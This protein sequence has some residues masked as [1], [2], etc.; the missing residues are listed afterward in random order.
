MSTPKENQQH[1]EQ[2]RS[3]A[4]APPNKAWL[5]YLQGATGKQTVYNA[6][7]KSVG[8]VYLLV[9]CSGSMADHDKMAQARRGAVGFAKQAQQKGYSVGVIQ[10]ESSARQIVAAKASAAELEAGVSRM[11]IGGGTNLAGGIELATQCFADAAG[12]RVICVITDGYPDDVNAALS[13]ARQAAAK[14][15]DIMALGTDDADEEFL[16]RLVT[17]KELQARVSAT[18][19]E[20]G[21]VAMAKLLPNSGSAS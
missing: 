11:E 15:I 7:S 6:A 8:V 9:D 3:V 19:L 12:E 14:R 18:Q 4:P 21:V 10:F 1:G 16:R 17:R 13:A 2:N 5:A 20:R